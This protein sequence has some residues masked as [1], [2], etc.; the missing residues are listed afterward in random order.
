MIRTL[1]LGTPQFAVPALEALLRAGCDVVAV[2]CQPDRPAGRGLRQTEPP[3]KKAAAARGIPVLQPCSLREPA[4]RA[5]IEG[6]RPDIAVV[7]AFG[8]KL[9]RWLLDLP[10]LGCYNIHASLL[11]KYRG[12]APIAHAILNGD[13]ETGVTIFRMVEKMDAGPVL[14]KAGIAILPAET[15]GEL[16]TRLADLGAKT[17]IESLGLLRANSEPGRAERLSEPATWRL[18]ECAKDPFT[19]QNEAEATLAPKLSKDDGRIN[20]SKAAEEIARQVRAFNPWPVAHTALTRAGNKPATKVGILCASVAGAEAFAKLCAAGA[21][22]RDVCDGAAAEEGGLATRPGTIMGIMPA[23]LVVSTGRGFL[24][25][26]R[27]RPES[28]PEMDARAFVNGYR[29]SPG[30][31]LGA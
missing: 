7:A 23:G 27:L 26:E 29:V 2:V 19:D 4:I 25:V 14:K 9:P 13:A 10:P 6:L 18:K 12:A 30:M 15:A 24:L 11:P 5:Q 17:M 1:F 16:E 8:Q 28:R 22:S 3:M 31:V 21:S 20:W